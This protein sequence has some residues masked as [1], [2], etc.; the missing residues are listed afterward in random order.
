MKRIIALLLMFT[1]AAMPAQAVVPVQA[2]PNNLI[3]NGVDSTT[4][5]ATAPYIDH[6]T[7]S[8]I[9]GSPVSQPMPSSIYGP[10]TD[11]SGQ[12]QVLVSPDGG[13]VIN[14][15]T[16]VDALNSTTANLASGASFVGAAKPDLQYTAVQF[17]VK[18]DQNMLIS[19]DQSSDGTNWDVTDTFEFYTSEGGTGSTVQLVA[20]YYRIRV[21][22][23]GASTSTFLRLQ[24]I[25]VPFL[26]SL[27]RSLDLDGN[28]KVAVMEGIT[29]ESGFISQNSP[30]GEILTAP[31]VQ[32]IG[33]AFATTT[34]DSNFWT[35][36]SGVGGT[37]AITNAELVLATGTTANNA[38]SAVST[39]SARFISG[40]TN[41]F[42]AGVRFP[43][44]ASSV[45]NTRRWGPYNATSG[46]HFDI[47]NGVLCVGTRLNSVDTLKCSGSF[48]GELG[49]AVV[50]N[51]NLTD[52]F[53]T[54][55]TGTVWFYINGKL[56]DTET[57]PQTN[58]TS[59]YNLP[60][61][62]ENINTGGSTTNVQMIVRNA[63]VH[64]LGQLL[65]QARSFFQ[66]GLTAGVT[67]K[68]GSGN[69]HGIVLSG[70]TNNSVLTVYD[71]TAASG[72]VV[73]TS[74]ALTSNGLPFFIDLKGITFSTGLTITVTGAAVN[75][76]IM[77]E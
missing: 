4:G 18:S 24:T 66:Q 56:L 21:V 44:S 59:T 22:N 10:A 14:Q 5:N 20:S 36:S 76:L 39:S 63:H 8:V 27:P 58:W 62:F 29:D 2:N 65:A 19:V 68:Q 37:S 7:G 34:L 74:G 54:Y 72:T 52:W 71:N 45:N 38:A 1:V 42:H 77:Y 67:L 25:A 73:W 70:I 35:A 31:S 49:T 61:T 60:I 50:M 3:Y 46:A 69:L 9:V 40:A 64:R 47:V 55:S 11:G 26:P 75:A 33:S 12:K 57:F 32:L 13:L 23:I 53:I 41:K 30:D 48:N 16:V 51:A 15:N 43:D 6:A 17:T 28:L